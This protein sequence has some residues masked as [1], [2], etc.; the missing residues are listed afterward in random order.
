MTKFVDLALITPENNDT[1]QEGEQTSVNLIDLPAFGIGVHFHMSWVDG[2]VNDDPG[3][4]SQLTIRRNVD[5]DR[6]FIDAQLIHDVGT[7]FHDL[8]VHICKNPR[9]SFTS[10][11]KV[12][13]VLE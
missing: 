2:W 9:I 6:L 3:S 4:S 7:E 5:Y 10:E 12:M 11:Q 1:V 8:F 13:G